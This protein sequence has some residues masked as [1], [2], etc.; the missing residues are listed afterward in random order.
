[1]ARAAE[2]PA[3]RP[4]AVLELGDVAGADLPHLDPRPE[5]AGQLMEHNVMTR[6]FFFGMHEQPVFR[7][8][9]LFADGHYP[10]T[11]HISR[12]GLYLPSGLTLTQEQVDYVCNAVKKVLGRT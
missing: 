5:L 1:M 6:P 11:E 2:V 9:G 12:Q 3:A 4:D 10:V 7:D 8:M